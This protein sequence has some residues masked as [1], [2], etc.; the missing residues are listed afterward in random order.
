MKK[1][2]LIIMGIFMFSDIVSIY[3]NNIVSRINYDKE[4]KVKLSDINIVKKRIAENDLHFTQSPGNNSIS[5]IS[6]GKINLIFDYNYIKTMFTEFNLINKNF[7]LYYDKNQIAIEK[8]IIKNLTLL[9]I[10]VRSK[11]ID[12]PIALI[13]TLKDD[14]QKMDGFLFLQNSNFLTNQAQQMLASLLLHLKK[15]FIS[16]GFSSQFPSIIT[17][18]PKTEKLVSVIASYFTDN[19]RSN[20]VM[21]E[22]KFNLKYAAFIGFQFKSDILKKVKQVI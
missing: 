15:I 19:K 7:I 14:S 9:N 20:I 18:V 3:G 5:F 1:I 12:D 21:N 22:L 13:R 6:G 4:L 2:I 16:F 10:K 11:Q 8:E 17:F